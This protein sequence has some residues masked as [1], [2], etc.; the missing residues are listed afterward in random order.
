MDISILDPMVRIAW[1]VG[2][3]AL[4]A[5]KIL[6]VTF[7]NRAAREMRARVERG[8]QCR[9]EQPAE[10]IGRVNGRR[11]SRRPERQ[12][13]QDHFE[14]EPGGHVVPERRPGLASFVNDMRGM[15]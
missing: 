15:S 2:E 12:A 13:A 6:A 4:P 7:T 11:P 1:L 10:S 14:R 5:W 9:G 8:R 3:R